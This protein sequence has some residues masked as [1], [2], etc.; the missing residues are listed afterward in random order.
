M[1]KTDVMAAMAAVSASVSTSY[2]SNVQPQAGHPLNMM[3]LSSPSSLHLGVPL[4]MPTLSRAATASPASHHNG[5]TAPPVV[6]N[7]TATTMDTAW[8]PSAVSG[9]IAV[10]FLSNLID[11]TAPEGQVSPYKVDGPY[12]VALCCLLPYT[13]QLREVEFFV[14]PQLYLKKLGSIP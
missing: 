14:S 9:K 3:N 7:S 5:A 8:P 13:T 4:R 2:S 12:L 1:L 6:C 11:Q 10:S